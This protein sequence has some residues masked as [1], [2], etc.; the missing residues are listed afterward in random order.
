MLERVDAHEGDVA[1]VGVADYRR[2]VD[3]CWQCK[4][5]FNHC[6][7]T[8][9]HKWDLDFPR[10]ML[11]A[12]AVRAKNEGVTF[13]DRW[14]GGIDTVGPIGSAAAPITNWVNRTKP[15]RVLLETAVGVHRDR[16]L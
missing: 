6:P 11:R 8:P 16:I 10:L 15:M 1:K 14:L 7:Y 5:C 12:K 9:P 2:I 13:Q 3:L 4:L